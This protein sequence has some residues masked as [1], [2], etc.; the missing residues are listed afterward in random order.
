MNIDIIATDLDLTPSLK[1]YVED[2]LGSIDKFI[3]KYDEKGSVHMRVEVGRTTRHHNKGD[4]FRAE[5]NLEVAGKLL[6]AEDENS[7]IHIAIDR[8]ED[9]LRRELITLKT[10]NLAARHS[11]EK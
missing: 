8:V 7:D 2:K 11:A 3:K 5:A 10:K 4:V 1:I 9:K 6:R